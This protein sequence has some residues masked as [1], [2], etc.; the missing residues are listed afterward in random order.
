MKEQK[1]PSSGVPVLLIVGVLI[2]VLIGAFWLYRSSSSNSGTAN[3]ANSNRTPAPRPTVPPNAP[4]GAQPPN[5]MGAPTATV[6]LEEFADFQCGSCAASH[7][8]LK[9]ITKAY[10]GNPNF[11][12]VFRN[13]P[14]QMHDKA[15]DAAVAAE[16]AGMQNSAKFW[17]MQDQL[18]TNQHTWSINQNYRELFNE[19]AQ[20]IGLDVERFKTDMAG[21]AAKSRVDLDLSRGRAL[22]IASTPTVII[23][24][25][26]VP[27]NEVTVA[28]L[29]RII[30]M[31][32]QSAN[33]PQQQSAPANPANATNK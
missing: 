3:V 12:F 27:Y 17:L 30:D 32:M 29:R 4:P 20:K 15:Y 6:V 7:P 19:Y 28:G 14:L 23:N 22:Q 9:D 11:R 8:V 31:E 33:A 16:A 25:R 5:A 10:S 2:A 1:K 26:M 18:F 21:M 13:F 24:N